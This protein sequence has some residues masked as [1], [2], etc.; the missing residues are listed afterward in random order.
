[1]KRVLS[2]V[3]SILIMVPLMVGCGTKNKKAEVIEKYNKNK[4]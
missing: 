4:L 1:M 2:L 3:M